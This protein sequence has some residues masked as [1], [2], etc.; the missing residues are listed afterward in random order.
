MDYLNQRRIELTNYLSEKLNKFDGLTPPV[1][2]DYVKHVFYVCA[3][4]Y[5]ESKI[6][7]PRISFVKALNAEGIPFGAGY[8]RPLYFSP[9]Y[10]QNK[11][12]FYKYYRGEASYE[13]GIC[14]NAEKLYSDILIITL[15]TRPPADFKDMDD[16]ARAIEKII[17]NKNEF[18]EKETNNCIL[19]GSSKHE[20]S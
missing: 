6:G 20:L 10:H 4:K 17:K 13:K 8:I 5:E 18:L 16:I 1:V 11:P 7:I 9:I 14:P 2:Y 15:L 19:W 12:Y 3:I